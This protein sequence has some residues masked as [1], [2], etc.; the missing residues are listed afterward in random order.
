M[1]IHI[2][3]IGGIGLSGIARFLKHEGHT[4]TGSD[5]RRTPLTEK[6]EKEGIKVNIP[7]CA[8]AVEGHDLV[9][10]SAAVKADNPE[11][12]EA[13]ERGILT[14]SRRESLPIVLGKS[15]VYSVCGAHGKSTTTAI[16]ASVLGSSALIGAES[17]AL[18]SNYHHE[19]GD[20]LAFEADESDESF[21]FSNPYCA[22][23]TNAEPEHMEYYNYDYDRFYAG[24]R[25]FLDL[26]KV[27]IINGED[28]Y[29]SSID[30]EAER[31]LPSKEITDIRYVVEK[32]E[33]RTLFTLRDL[34]EFSVWGFGEH[35]AM[36]AS[37]AILAA[38]HELDLETIR[39]NIRNYKG[40]KKRFDILKQEKGHVVIDD[41]G[42][43]PT[44]IEAT[45]E[46]VREYAKQ[47]GLEKITVIW[48][49][50][51]Y[52][53]TVDN[54]ERFVEC[55]NGVDELVILPVW[56]A[57]EQEVELHLEERFKKY[58][59]HFVDDVAAA[60]KSLDLKKGLVIGFGAGDIS[61]QLR[62]SV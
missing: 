30:V 35:I 33:P 10:H 11:L 40:I 50:H 41:Y 54:L 49:P 37:L 55:F 12:V 6:L 26:A 23:V 19:E 57:G 24:Y 53:R 45:L 7:H 47:A 31:L 39:K 56:S 43:H 15:K 36:D 27:R 32:G 34:G 52:S 9:I 8:T 2:V 44:E 17:K 61:L 22:I 13:R 25:K 42:H 29:L 51:K 3:G 4:V 59:P 58:A 16:L 5:I 21:L 18:G 20:L 14:L 28:A 38:L 48:Q 1:N 60:E 62:K 46:S